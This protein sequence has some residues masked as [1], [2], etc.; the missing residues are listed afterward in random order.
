[1]KNNS[2]FSWK[3]QPHMY[4]KNF[5]SRG[6]KMGFVISDFPRT[7]S[8]PSVLFPLLTNKSNKMYTFSEKER[9]E[10]YGI[11]GLLSSIAL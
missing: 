11:Q 5:I 7:C 1:M 6:F 9:I 8:V 3:N 4:K 2:P 10:F